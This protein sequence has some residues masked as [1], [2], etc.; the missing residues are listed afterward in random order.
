VATY[1]DSTANVHQARWSFGNTG[2]RNH[3]LAVNDGEAILHAVRSDLGKS[4]MPVFLQS[5]C[6]G[7]QLLYYYGT[8]P[9][10]EIWLIVHPQIHRLARIQAIMTWIASV[11]SAV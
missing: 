2:G 6:D 1:D 5:R 8:V 10:R 9:S 3:A 4:L 11:L 7:L